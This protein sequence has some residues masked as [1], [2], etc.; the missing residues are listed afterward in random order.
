MIL[1]FP[2]PFHHIANCDR[3]KLLLTFDRHGKS[4]SGAETPETIVAIA[5][6]ASTIEHHE[7]LRTRRIEG[8][9]RRLLI[10]LRN[11]VIRSYHPSMRELTRC[12]SYKLAGSQG[13]FR[14]GGLHINLES[15]QDFANVHTSY[16]VATTV[17][18][19]RCVGTIVFRDR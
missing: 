14:S 1:E 5:K 2:K 16:D 10:Q 7:T 8:C 3:M 9:R 15:M 12:L 11:K 19:Y 6:L 13:L 17:S 18:K 4:L